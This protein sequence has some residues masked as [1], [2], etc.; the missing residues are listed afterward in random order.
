MRRLKYVIYFVV[1][2]MLMIFAV[3]NSHKTVIYYWDQ[4]PLF[5]GK[6]VQTSEEIDVAEQ[7]SA[8][9]RGIPVFLVDFVCFGIGWVASWFF[10]WAVMKR[11]KKNNKKL[12]KELEALEAEMQKMQ[13]ESIFGDATEEENDQQPSKTEVAST[14]T[15]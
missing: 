3:S 2:V 13:E 6:I 4:Q 15:G 14:D 8:E 1:F 10:G 11:L 7:D 12:R 9:Y 5:G